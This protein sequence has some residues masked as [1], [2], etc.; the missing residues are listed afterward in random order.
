MISRYVSTLI[1]SL[2]WVRTFNTID[3]PFSYTN[4]FNKNLIRELVTNYNLYFCSI[5]I[6]AILLI[7]TKTLNIEGCV[8][9][10]FLIIMLFG[11]FKDVLRK[12][13]IYLF[14]TELVFICSSSTY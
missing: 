10:M 1:L 9:S 6:V 13:V 14:I 11:A 8:S 2:I 3:D 7:L 5:F 4:E 12:S